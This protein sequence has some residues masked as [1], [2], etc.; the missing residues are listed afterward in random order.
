MHFE[1]LRINLIKITK[2]IFKKNC[3][4][5]MDSFR[6][7]R[8]F[9]MKIDQSQLATEWRKWKRSLEYFLAASGI[10]GQREMRNQ[11]LHLGGP[12]LQDIFD[13]LPGV[14]DIPH[15]TP[16]PPF[17]DVAISTLEAHFQPCR[18]RTYE[19]HVFRQIAQ[20]PG[21]RFG[22][23]VMKLRVQAKRCDFDLKGT[24]VTESMI[25]DQIAEKC[26]SSAL[27][28]KVL[29]KDR[30]LEEVVAIGKTMEDVELQC[31]E[32]SQ[33]EKY[34]ATVETVNKVNFQRKVPPSVSGY[35]S[36][37]RSHDFR[38]DRRQYVNTQS[39]FKPDGRPNWN[40]PSNPRMAVKGTDERHPNFDARICFGCGRR[41]HLRGGSV[42][43]AKDAQCRKCCS[44]GHFA[45][46]CTKRQIEEA[47][48]M[49]PNKRIKAVYE[50]NVQTKTSDDKPRSNTDA[51]IC[52]VMGENV[53]RFIVGGVGVEM[54]IDSG[55]AANLIDCRTWKALQAKGAK[56]TYSTKVNRSFKAYGSATPLKIIGMFTA[57]IVAGDSKAIATFYVAE[58]GTQSLLGDETAKELKVLKI[59]YN[60]GSVQASEIFPKI[61]GVLVEIPVDPNVKPVQQPYRRA[62]FALEAKIT[63]KLQ[64]LLDRDII[65][66][67]DEPS[68]WVSPI[69]PILKD[70]GEIRLCVDMRRVNKAIL[71]ET[72][73]LP[74][75]EELFGGIN[76]AIRFSKLDI[77]EAYH[78]VEFAKRSRA[79]PTFITKQGLF[80]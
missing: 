64:S 57:V 58:N 13:N 22:D 68:P 50:T 65:E 78:Q 46:W 19:R 35:R 71:R 67:V 70:N 44:F 61:K 80:R 76:G 40:V 73:P 2:K 18:R 37:D 41:G 39:R 38:G 53:F 74:I 8:P 33:T 54:T 75:V 7:I 10:T 51:E 77:K 62:P 43:I 31:K 12:D 6:P 72:H 69:V 1:I 29:E 79:V 48:E 55:A 36:L 49:V 23:F 59:G 9:D 14:H 20:L 32:M 27:R 3:L 42:C 52:Y 15:V 45:K 60:V 17:Y 28:K 24:S 63:E 56:L 5:Q 21:E 4:K 30:P 11:L 66:K 47:N 16:D 34:K 25:I 26:S